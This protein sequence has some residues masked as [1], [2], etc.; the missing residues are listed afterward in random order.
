MRITRLQASL[1]LIVIGAIL[2]ILGG[3]GE[4]NLMVTLVG[5]GMF[6]VGAMAFIRLSSK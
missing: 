6:I 5:G 1:V 3:T 2:A 4:F